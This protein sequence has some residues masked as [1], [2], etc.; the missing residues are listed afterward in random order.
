[1]PTNDFIAYIDV[2]RRW[3]SFIVRVVGTTLVVAVIVSFLLPKWYE[4]RSTVMAP[5]DS[6][7]QSGLMSFVSGLSSPALAG[8][9]SGSPESQMYLAILNSRSLRVSLIRKFGMQAV[10]KVKTMD[11]AVQAFTK[12]A[13]ASIN[14]L[15]VLEVVVE[16]RDP[17]RASDIANA[18]VKELDE[19]NK[20]ARMTTG[21]K[22]RQ[23]VEMRLRETRERLQS[24]EEALA[25]YQRSHKNAAVA[26]GSSRG[27]DTEGSILAQRMAL[28]I[29]INR[30]TDVYRHDAP[31]V[32]QARAELAAIDQ[33]IGQLPGMARD[34]ARLLRDVK[35]QE[36]VYSLLVA[37]YEEA[38]IEENKDTPT[39]D[40]LD[41][42]TRP[43]KK[44]RPVRW[45]FVL[46]LVAAASVL[47]VGSAFAVE[48]LKSMNG[49]KHESP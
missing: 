42:A 35:E 32:V 2:L 17:Q 13:R 6:G 29:R 45:L 46:S 25:V 41:A 8:L 43:E 38:R 30:L 33:Q 36:Q 14:D 9:A 4:A 27:A 7:V 15:G 34:Y 47:S 31:E 26:L 48:A 22:T 5:Q 39:L 12:H 20:I 21:K 28:S 16:D 18:W 40:V 3:R 23:F 37:Q 44:I 11:D 49:P 10:Y 19:F 1:M 24:A